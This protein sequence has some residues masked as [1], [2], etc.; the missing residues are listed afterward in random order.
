M[1][2]P[3]PCVD[4]EFKALISALTPDEYQLLED[5]LLAEGCR[6]DLVTWRGLLVDGHNR[7]EIC[8]RYGIDYG[9][10]RLDIMPNRNAALRWI[11]T[12]QLGRRNLTPFNR[13]ELALKLEPV[14]REQARENQSKAAS[15]RQSK[16][17]DLQAKIA[18]SSLGA[19][20]SIMARSELSRLRGLP[21]KEERESN[22]KVYFIRVDDRVKIGFSE[23]PEERLRH[24]RAM[25]PGA[26]IVATIPG[27]L[28]VEKDL[29]ARFAAYHIEGE[30]F[31]AK[32]LG[33]I[34]SESALAEFCQSTL[35]P[36]NAR[37]EMA[38]AAHLSHDTISKVKTLIARAPEPVKERLRSGETSINAEYTRIV[39][40]DELAEI[41]ESYAR[42]AKSGS[43]DTAVVHHNAGEW[44]LPQTP[45]ESADLLL[46]D[47]PYLTHVDDIE[48]FAH[49]WLPLA[50]SRVKRTGRA[51]VFVGAYP[52]ELLAYLTAPRAG[53]ELPQ[54]LVWTYRNTL[55]PSPLL[56]YKLNWQAVLYFRGPDAAPLDCPLMNEQ[57]SVQD[58]C[59][60]DGRQGNRW[61]EWQKPDEI[62]ERFIRHATKPGDLVIDPFAGTG[63]FLAAA[64]RLGR[65]AEGCEVDPCQIALCRER[66][67]VV[68]GL[69]H[70]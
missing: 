5:S 52:D 69:H 4:P 59:A 8:Q 40:A 13:A 60:P 50:L 33:Q 38:K 67:I 58:I 28:H 29:H 19:V 44:F 61:H 65:M 46:T 26:E 21:A 14:I 35:T 49:S 20:E 11:I 56:D 68:K 64:A 15:D 16:I 9:I 43:P 41:K 45:A 34:G 62:A 7:L 47:P 42:L 39:K 10:A 32:M 2:D 54:V 51:Y 24:I 23:Y 17:R 1:S 27:G 53:F 63:T 6:D 48:A 30:W 70:A 18:D 37:R 22:Q 31:S 12:N 3:E 66:G 25:N 57:F 36:H 55:G